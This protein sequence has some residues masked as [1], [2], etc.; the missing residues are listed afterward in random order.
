VIGCGDATSR[1]ADGDRVRVDG[2]QGT[3]EI[4]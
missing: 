2:A 4:L 1:L 3:V